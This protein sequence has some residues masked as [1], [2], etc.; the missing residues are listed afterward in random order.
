MLLNTFKEVLMLLA[1]LM[2]GLFLMEF[3]A[4][5]LLDLIMREIFHPKAGL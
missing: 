3:F 1:G 2:I 4:S 5:L